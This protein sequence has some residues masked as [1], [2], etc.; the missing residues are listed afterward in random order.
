MEKTTKPGIRVPTAKGSIAF[1]SDKDYDRKKRVKE[2]A[3]EIL[4]R[5]AKVFKKLRESGD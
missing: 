1:K 4:I 2:I 3:D 5:H